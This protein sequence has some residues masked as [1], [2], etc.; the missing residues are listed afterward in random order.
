MVVY[1]NSLVS[2]EVSRDPAE[3][4]LSVWNLEGEPSCEDFDP[5]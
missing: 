1:M 2:T 3:I 5:F 4:D